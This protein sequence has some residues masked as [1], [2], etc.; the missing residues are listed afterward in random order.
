M[1]RSNLP[2]PVIRVRTLRR[3]V[4]PREREGRVLVAAVRDPDAVYW[5]AIWLALPT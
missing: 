5:A 1:P 4:R 3:G 2:D